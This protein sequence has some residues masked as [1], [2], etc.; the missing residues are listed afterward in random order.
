[1][2]VNAFVI[3][4]DG[5]PI[6]YQGQEQH[7]TGGTDPYTNREALWQSGFNIFHPLYVDI[8]ALNQIRHHAFD[9]QGEKYGK[10]LTTVLDDGDH[11]IVLEKGEKG[12][13][14]LTILNNYGQDAEDFSVDFKSNYTSGSSLTNILTCDTVSVGDD[15]AV[16]LTVTGGLPVV[17]FGTDLLKGSNLCGTDGERWHGD[18]NITSTVTTHSAYTTTI[19]GQATEATATAIL[20]VVTQAEAAAG[21]QITTESASA[22]AVSVPVQP[23][24]AGVIP[25]VAVVLTSGLMGAMLGYAV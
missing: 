11:H 23:M 21:P 6:V 2:N 13:E 22:L 5:M 3:M 17:L 15:G 1:M 24:M 8:A 14:I 12:K 16:E 7:F 10:S 19:G 20:P 18:A 4:F 9:T 25:A